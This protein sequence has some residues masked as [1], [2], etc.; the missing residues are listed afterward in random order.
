E[1]EE[2]HSRGVQ[3]SLIF[4]LG[5]L[6]YLSDEQLRIIRRNT[7]S[8][9]VRALVIE[10]YTLQ[11]RVGVGGM[12]EVFRAE[13]DDGA[14]LAVKLLPQKMLDSGEYLG[15]FRRE[16]R[17][18]GKLQHPHITAFHGTGVVEGRPYFLM[19]LVAGRS[20]KAHLEQH[21]PLGPR[22]TLLLMR[23][24]ADALRFAWQFGV[25]HRDVKPSNIILGAPRRGMEEP[26][27]A[28]LCDFGLAKTRM[29]DEDE[30]GSLTKSGMAVGTPHYMSPEVATGSDIVEPCIDIYSLGA[31]AYH[32]LTGNTLYH[33]KSSAVIMY[34]QATARIDVRDLSADQASPAMR[35]LLADMLDKECSKRIHDWDEVIRRLDDLLE[36][37]V[38]DSVGV[39]SVSRGQAVVKPW[40][41][42]QMSIVLVV[43]ILVLAGVLLLFFQAGTQR[44]SIPAEPMSFAFKLQQAERHLRQGEAVE[45]SLQPGTYGGPWF[46]GRAHAGLQVRAAASGVVLRGTEGLEESLCYIDAGCTDLQLHGISMEQASR[47]AIQMGEGAGLR[48]TGIDINQVEGLAL[49]LDAATVELHGCRIDGVSGGIRAW[50]GSHLMMTESVLRASGPLLE[51]DQSQM[52]FEACRLILQTDEPVAHG[53]RVV[54]GVLRMQDVVV[55][56]SAALVGGTLERINQVMLSNCLVVGGETGIRAFNI[57]AQHVSR[58]GVQAKSVGV[59]WSGPWD[60]LWHWQD[61]AVRAPEP[62]RGEQIAG[63]AVDGAGPEIQVLNRLPQVSAD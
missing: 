29:R 24:M 26:F 22:D 12:G 43:I 2:L 15:R 36:S 19:E 9:T 49:L 11:G 47:A 13:R 59:Q 56:A 18:L 14:V 55:E 6:G 27:C 23:Q 33:G 10:G 41:F 21:G 35:R 4:V 50:R 52:E 34:K 8:S 30:S 32:T 63:M 7:S 5:D 53:M 37:G 44:I 28:K 17:I 16:A 45:L 46:F 31:T 51:A 54:G 38:L 61:L 48:A 57:A 25:V 60:L 1:V 58:V 42:V 39:V 20:L 3:R 62:L 40:A